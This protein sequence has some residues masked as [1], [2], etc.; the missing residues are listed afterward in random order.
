MAILKKP[1]DTLEGEKLTYE[2]ECAALQ[3]DSRAALI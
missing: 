2:E 1:I 3:E